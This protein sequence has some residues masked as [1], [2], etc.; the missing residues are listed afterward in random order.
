M[1]ARMMVETSHDH[2]VVVERGNMA[3]S[4]AALYTASEPMTKT[5][6]E[7]AGLHTEGTEGPLVGGE[8][9]YT[10]D[11]GNAGNSAT[12][13]PARSTLVQRRRSH[14]RL[15]LSKWRTMMSKWE[16]F[17]KRMPGKIQ[18]RVR[19]GIPPPLRGHIWMAL[20]SAS[21]L[22]HRNP[23]VY[24]ACLIAQEGTDTTRS[25]SRSTGHSGTI[26]NHELQNLHG[27]LFARYGESGAWSSSCS[28]S[29]SESDSESVI[30][31]DAIDSDSSS[32]IRGQTFIS[33]GSASLTP[34]RKRHGIKTKD[35]SDPSNITVIGAN[36]A[37]STHITNK[38]NN[39]NNINTVLPSVLPGGENAAKVVPSISSSSPSSSFSAT[40]SVTM[41]STSVSTQKESLEETISRDI[42]RT[43]PKHQQFRDCGGLGQRS[44]FHVL[45]AYAQFDPS[46]GYC[47]GMG[48]IAALLLTMLPEESSFWALV[49][50]MQRTK[51]S[52]AGLFRSGLPRLQLYQA[53]LENLMRRRM[54]ET[55][56]H[57]FDELGVIPSSFAP[58][59][60]MTVFICSFPLT[61]T[62]RVWDV[63]LAEGWPFAFKIMLA[64][65]ELSTPAL[66][67]MSNFED[68]LR[69][70]NEEFPL[71]VPVKTLLD[72][73]FGI[74]LTA[75]EF[76]DLESECAETLVQD[77]GFDRSELEREGGVG[78]A[79]VG[80]IVDQPTSHENT[81]INSH[82]VS[83]VDAGNEQKIATIMM[84]PTKAV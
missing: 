46:V 20:T 84:P 54:P 9:S 29:D 81:D 34:E 48:Y 17:E 70:L 65:M 26:S 21:V 53:M 8:L 1:A 35:R 43:F 79:E 38:S 5:G 25:S 36:G 51:Y 6:T 47:Q 67:A 63:F 52:M 45:R 49:S 71:T 73:A 83:N 50:L 60:I 40:K 18:Q 78:E 12:L 37:T 75:K 4:A 64:L 57:L 31:S 62:I 58:Q 42:G 15:K 59:W 82:S 74:R 7:M 11:A 23:G 27:G 33:P 16:Y 30:D 80:S 69:L 61:L 56:S 55:A 39:N 72:T 24:R 14:A 22:K 32:N 44:L 19:R 66:L 41:A 76:Q 77:Y 68:A 3:V 13:H 10:D 28:D 2:A